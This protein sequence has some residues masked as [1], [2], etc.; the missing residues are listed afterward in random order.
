LYDYIIVDEAS[1]VDLATGVLAMSC[2]TRMIVVG[3]KNNFL[4]LFQKIRN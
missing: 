3:M 1:Q 2:A 4:M